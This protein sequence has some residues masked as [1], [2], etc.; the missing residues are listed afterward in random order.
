M[1][2]PEEREELEQLV[3]TSEDVKL[4]PKE[5]D[6]LERILNDPSSEALIAEELR[7]LALDG[8]DEAMAGR[9][10]QEAFGSGD[11][12]AYAFVNDWV[13]N[14]YA[15]HIAA[16]HNSAM[17]FRRMLEHVES[18]NLD[19]AL[20]T[21]QD[22]YTSLADTQDAWDAYTG[23]ALRL[24]EQM[25]G[26]VEEIRRT[27]TAGNLRLAGVGTAGG[28]IGA[29]KRLSE[30][31]A[32]VIALLVNP[33]RA[34]YDFFKSV[35]KVVDAAFRFGRMYAKDPAEFMPKVID[36]LSR[37]SSESLERLSK[38]PPDQQAWAVGQF[39]GEI[40]GDLIPLAA[41]GSIGGSLRAGATVATG[42]EGSRIL[43]GARGLAFAEAPVV[44]GGAAAATLA[45]ADT[46]QAAGFLS[47][48][49]VAG[50][51][52]GGGQ[53]GKL[54]EGQIAKYGEFKKR[55][56]GT[57]LAGHEVIPHSLLKELK[58]AIRRGVGA[59]SRNNPAIA[60]SPEVHAMVGRFQRYFGVFYRSQRA[61]KS[62][63]KIISLNIKALRAAGVPE[64]VVL[65]IS[66]QGARPCGEPED[67]PLAPAWRSAH[68][69]CATE[70]SSNSH[71]AVSPTV[72]RPASV[73]GPRSTASTTATRR[74]PDDSTSTSPSR[75]SV[76]GPEAAGSIG[77]CRSSG[78]RPPTCRSIPAMVPAP[79]T[80]AV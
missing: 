32:G 18:G 71:V 47:A 78:V 39:F 80:T 79:F 53:T 72:S 21:G 16:W 31:A 54:L 25:I 12:T 68:F 76:I 70:K 13:S 3:G 5:R 15:P 24:G 43:Q 6:E 52:R 51:G 41:A 50:G 20:R 37:Q 2:A 10:E 60:L 58:L 29:G 65:D 22:G 61:G 1:L 34:T 67:H 57:G 36:A 35:Q 30:F 40:E 49:A 33:G 17:L 45:V 28:V 23:E 9:A 27:G 14:R 42:L 48:F 66:R 19:D 74:W 69:A 64:S 77:N 63:A 44:V 59:A 38:L 73:I 56:R 62:V 7:H 55:A 8:I 26:T 4:D 75:E 46:V 11:N